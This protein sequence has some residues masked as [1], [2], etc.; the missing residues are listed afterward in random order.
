MNCWLEVHS[1]YLPWFSG[2]ETGL[3]KK[4]IVRAFEIEVP[5]LVNVQRFFLLVVHLMGHL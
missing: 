5:L 1:C 3:E 2:A 4:F